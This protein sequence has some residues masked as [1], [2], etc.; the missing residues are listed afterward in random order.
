MNSFKNFH[1]N[2]LKKKSKSLHDNDSDEESKEDLSQT[3][4][5]IFPLIKKINSTECSMPTKNHRLMQCPL[6]YC[7]YKFYVFNDDLLDRSIVICP[8][9]HNICAEVFF[10]NFHIK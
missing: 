6:S 4:S 7:N 2:S 9:G 3:E 10:I 1:K 8:Q 5:I